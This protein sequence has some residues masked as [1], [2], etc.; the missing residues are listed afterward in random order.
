M[1]LMNEDEVKVFLLGR[2]VD[3]EEINDDKFDVAKQ[4]HRYLEAGGSILACGTCLKVR[5]KSEMKSC[6]LSTM[7][8]LLDIVEKSDKI[9]TF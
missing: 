6:S 1:A 2:G 5:E 9:L 3:I 7:Q 8:D 4:K